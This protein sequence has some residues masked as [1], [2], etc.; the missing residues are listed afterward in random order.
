MFVTG[1]VALALVL[2]TAACLM[3]REFARELKESNGFNPRHLLIAKLDVSSRRYKEGDARIALFEQVTENLRNVSDVEAADMDSCV[4]M[5]CFYSTSF[6]VVGGALLRPSNRPS[7]GFFVVGPDYFR[8]MQIPLMKGREFSA[9]DNA[10]API[11]AVLDEELATRFFREDNA[12]GKQIEVED[13][14]HKQAQIVGMVGNV[15]DYAGEISPHPHVYE[16]Y[17]QIPVNAFQ[18]WR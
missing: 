5:D 10:H 7:A 11:V 2:L 6:D 16:T 4:P 18:R 17:L 14:N 13:G 12:V 1:E 9:T 8:T 15:N 3:M